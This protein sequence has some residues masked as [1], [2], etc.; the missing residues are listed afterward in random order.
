MSSREDTPRLEWKSV[1]RKGKKPP[2]FTFAVRKLENGDLD[3]A[4]P[5]PKKGRTIPIREEEIT[6][7]MRVRAIIEADRRRRNIPAEG[8]PLPGEIPDIPKE[9]S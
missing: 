9:K 8:T 6:A 1:P 5:P 4:E 7:G 2:T 3:W